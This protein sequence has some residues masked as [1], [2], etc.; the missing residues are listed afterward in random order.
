M[1]VRKAD[2][3]SE[4]LGFPH[5]F[6]STICSTIVIRNHGDGVDSAIGTRLPEAATYLRQPE[7]KANEEHQSWKGRAK[8]VQGG[9]VGLQDA[10]DRD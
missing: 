8:M 4:A 9:W 5:K 7:D 1:S 2:A 6:N 10:E 3:F